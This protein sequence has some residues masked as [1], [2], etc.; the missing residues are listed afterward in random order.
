MSAATHQTTE[1]LSTAC[2]ATDGLAATADELHLLVS[3]FRC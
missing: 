2:E 1:S 3:Q